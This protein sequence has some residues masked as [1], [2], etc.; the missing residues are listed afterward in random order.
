MGFASGF[1]DNLPPEDKMTIQEGPFA[2]GTVAQISRTVLDL[3]SWYEEDHEDR[4]EMMFSPR[5]DKEKVG[6][7]GQSLASSSRT[8]EEIADAAE[9]DAR[10]RG[11]VGHAQKLA[12]ARDEDFQATVLRRDFDSTDGSDARM[13]FMGFMRRIDDFV[14]MQEAM[15]GAHLDAEPEPERNGILGFFEAPNRA[16]Y[17]V[18]PRRLRALPPANPES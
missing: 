6:E 9:E 4:V 8:T 13:E 12:G 14:E 7:T 3:E 1:T 16:T 18:P 5:H 11:V 15:R 10:E 17:L 2:G